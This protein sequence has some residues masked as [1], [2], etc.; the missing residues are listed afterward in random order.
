GV[1]VGQAY[2]MAFGNDVRNAGEHDMQG[3]M[4]AFADLPDDMR[5]RIAQ[6]ADTLPP[7]VRE[8]LDRLGLAPAHGRNAAPAVAAREGVGVPRG[9]AA[10]ANQAAQAFG[11][12]DARTTALPAQAAGTPFAAQEAA[13]RGGGQ[14]VG[15]MQQADRAL[16]D[17]PLLQPG[18]RTAEGAVA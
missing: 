4:Q 17:M 2:A 14:Q 12:A 6:G 16:H 18:G 9:E 1:P 8:A 5:Q 7:P 10:P 3:L 15:P 11:G 13:M